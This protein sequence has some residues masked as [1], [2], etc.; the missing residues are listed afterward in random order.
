MHPN[1]VKT[2]LNRLVKKGVISYKEGGRRFLYYPLVAKEEFYDTQTHRFLNQFF[3]GRLSS[4]VSHFA[5]HD[6]LTPEEVTQIKTLIDNM[7]KGHE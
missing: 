5:K 4:L 1:T 2:L 6:Q 7:D 3:D